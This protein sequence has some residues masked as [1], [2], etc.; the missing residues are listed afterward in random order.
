MKFVQKIKKGIATLAKIAICMLAIATVVGIHGDTKTPAAN[1]LSS[2]AQK[3]YPIAY[4][5]IHGTT[6]DN[7]HGWASPK[8]Y[9][10]Q[11]LET[12]IQSEGGH[13]FSFGWCGKWH[14]EARCAA[15][16]KLADTI[17][18]NI[19]PNYKKIV[20]ITHSH[21]TN[22]FS[23]ASHILVERGITKAVEALYSLA[24]PICSERDE[25]YPNME[26]FTKNGGVLNIFSLGDGYQP[27]FG[28]QR[29]YDVRSGERIANISV[30]LDG[31]LPDHAKVHSKEMAEAIPAL[32]KKFF[33][34]SSPTERSKSI[35]DHQAA[36]QLLFN[37][38]GAIHLFTDKASQYEH[39]P[40]QEAALKSDCYMQTFSGL[41]RIV[42]VLMRD[43]FL[44]FKK[45]WVRWRERHVS[46][47]CGLDA[48]LASTLIATWSPFSILHP[49][50]AEEDVPRKGG[51][52]CGGSR[53]PIARRISAEK[54]C[55]VY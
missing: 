15:A 51:I 35:T 28:Y 21:G 9:F 13:I 50:D 53:G 12:T 26:I 23:M 19:M 22:I 11:S 54:I 39:D 36:S 20:F 37:Q 7:K 25:Y 52:I 31:K 49:A 4:V 16:N 6:S 5:I 44:V 42:P 30:T 29:T 38:P 43:I 48:I 14:H 47:E 41:L 18:N 34:D 1:T 33:S 45:T 3:Q 24:T 27:R 10:Y 17:E 8:G 55:C 40:E 2:P 46:P 32:H